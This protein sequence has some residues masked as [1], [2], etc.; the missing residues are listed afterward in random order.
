MQTDSQT[1]PA[2]VIDRTFANSLLRCFDDPGAY[3]VHQ[4][5]NEWW[6]YAPDSTIEKYLADFR[7]APEQSQFGR[8]RYF[9]EPQNLEVLGRLAA[10]TLGRA[11]FDFIV[12][13]NLE[14]NIAI[15]YRKFHESLE[16]NGTLKRMPE[17]LK[18]AIIRGFQIH[19]LLH[20]LTG[21]GA[22]PRAEI[23]LQAFCLAQI[24]FPYFGMWV[25]NV[26]TRM[27]FLDPDMITPTMDAITEGWSFGRHTQNL[28]FA[29]WE[30]MFDQ[31]VA[32]LR[33]RY[34]IAENGG[35]AR[36]A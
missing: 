13:N 19:D 6:Q 31:P 28:Q 4:L 14:K 24:R 29:K 17:D 27:T 32:A 3:G 22:T 16:A 8:E 23:A 12:D 20:V 35:M 15:N 5:F 11:Y 2:L 9:A 25:S 10:G 34:G 33:R 18:Y 21:Y 36:A 7:S 26:T 1:G 30:A